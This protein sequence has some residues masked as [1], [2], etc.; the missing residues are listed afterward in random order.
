MQSTDPRKE[1]LTRVKL[2]ANF[3]GFWGGRVRGVELELQEERKN[4]VCNL[5]LLLE[6]N[7]TIK[8]YTCPLQ[9]R[10]I[11]DFVS[12]GTRHGGRYEMSRS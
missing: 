3:H 1:T 4:E 11:V 7:S 2:K 6:S 10:Y 12:F 8:C 5:E 9:S